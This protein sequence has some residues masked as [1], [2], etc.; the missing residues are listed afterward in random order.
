MGASRGSGRGQEDSDSAELD[1]VQGLLSL[2]QDQAAGLEGV[3]DSNNGDLADLRSPTSHPCLACFFGFEAWPQSGGRA[4][5]RHPLLAASLSILHQ[6]PIEDDNESVQPSSRRSGARADPCGPQA[7]QTPPSDRLDSTDRRPDETRRDDGACALTLQTSIYHSHGRPQVMISKLPDDGKI[8]QPTP[9]T[10]SSSDST[11]Q[12]PTV[13]R[14]AGTRNPPSYIDLPKSQ[15]SAQDSEPTLKLEQDKDDGMSKSP[16]KRSSW[17]SSLSSR[18]SSSEKTATTSD[19]A[20]GSE[21]ARRTSVDSTAQQ[22]SNARDVS[23]LPSP[24]R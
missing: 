4:P 16:S 12:I 22:N 11:S 7:S 2:S 23:P 3:D 1:C 17:M 9:L 5:H 21:S 10:A 15:S 20:T 18:F 13:P 24:R 6:T 19:T 8:I 14:P